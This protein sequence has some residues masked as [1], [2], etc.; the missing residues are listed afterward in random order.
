[1][2]QSFQDMSLIP[3]FSW[4]QWLSAL[5]VGCLSMYLYLTKDVGK[6]EKRGMFSVRPTFLLGNNAEMILGRKNLIAFHRWQYDKY[7]AHK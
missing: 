5:A 4:L 3:E 2:S 7:K 6:W 1:M